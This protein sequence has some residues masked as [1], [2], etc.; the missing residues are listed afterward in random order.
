MIQI[1][2]TQNV[3]TYFLT[4]GPLQFYDRS[5]GEMSR[6]ELV[7]IFSSFC[8]IISTIVVF[9]ISRDVSS[10][11]YSSLLF[12]HCT[13]T[14]H[15]VLNVSMQE[16]NC[17]RLYTQKISNEL[18]YTQM[19]W[20][21]AFYQVVNIS[22]SISRGEVE[23]TNNF[24]SIKT[25]HEIQEEPDRHQSIVT[26]I[27]ECCILAGRDLSETL[28]A[29]DGFLSVD[30]LSLAA[31][32]VV[33]DSLPKRSW[34]DQHS[35]KAR[36]I[37]LEETNLCRPGHFQPACVASSCWCIQHQWDWWYYVVLR[38]L[39]AQDFELGE[40]SMVPMYKCTVRNPHNVCSWGSFA[41]NVAQDRER[42]S[43]WVSW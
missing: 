17:K 1:V 7:V 16:P 39:R 28:F 37:I 8:F 26:M 11:H 22:N 10:P 14:L 15:H 38:R 36:D 2:F 40:I 27:V 35:R 20:K 18:L 25:Y 34:F 43:W 32:A 29:L 33:H 5:F 6:D 4:I 24:R 9:S 19:N 41:S 23:T 30:C 13:K 3:I 12:R 31:L 21:C 42:Q